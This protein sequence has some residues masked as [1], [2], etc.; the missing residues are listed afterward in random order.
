[1]AGSSFSHT[2]ED[3]GTYDYFCMVHPWMIGTVIV[4]DASEIAA[5]IAAQEEEEAAEA[6]A[7][8]AEE[9]AWIEANPGVVTNAPGSSTPGCEETNSCFIP[10]T[11]TVSSGQGITWYNNDTAAHTA[12]SGTPTEGPSGAFDSSLIMAG[13]SYNHTF[14]SV[15]TYDYFCM[16]HPWMQGTV[17]VESASQQTE[18][19]GESEQIEFEPPTEVIETEAEVVTESDEITT[20]SEITIETDIVN[21]QNNSQMF[22]YI[23]QIKNESGMVL[24]VSI[25]SGSLG[26]GQ[27]LTQAISWTP[28][29]PGVYV[30][31][32]YLWDDMD[33]GNPLSGVETQYFTVT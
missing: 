5:F 22:A 8:A 31:E 27:T 15:G 25:I 13:G 26:E 1:M 24:S 10:S 3:P 23:V 29:D 19:E 21:Q 33:M 9:A 30:A 18:V 17:V 6:A 7:A 20:G 32:I 12:T 4:G 28:D 14:Y 16:V 11:I 2:F